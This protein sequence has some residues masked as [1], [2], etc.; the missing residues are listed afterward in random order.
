M[1]TAVLDAGLIFHA[2]RIHRSLRVAFQLNRLMEISSER[3]RSLAEL[4]ADVLDHILGFPC[5]SFMVIRLW[6]CCNRLL[7]KK[8]ASVITFLELRH[9]SV[10]LLPLRG[11]PRMLSELRGLRHLSIKAKE[12]KPEHVSSW[13]TMLRSLPKTLTTLKFLV[14]EWWSVFLISDVHGAS[15]D[16]SCAKP[17]QYKRGESSMMDLGKHFPHLQA[18]E[19][20]HDSARMLLNLI[21]ALPDTL[22]HLAISPHNTIGHRAF[23]RLPLSLT[24]L[25]AEVLGGV[26]DEDEDWFASPSP[27]LVCIRSIGLLYS[28]TQ[29]HALWMPRSLVKAGMVIG[30]QRTI[31]IC[32]MRTLP[33]LLDSLVIKKPHQCSPTC[34]L[35]WSELPSHLTS[36]KINFIV[37]VT[38]AMIF[39]LPRTI[40]LL[41]FAA[42]LK[43]DADDL[44]LAKDDNGVPKEPSFW[45]PLLVD[46]H[47][48]L[49]LDSACDSRIELLPRTLTA[50]KI[51][52]V[53]FRRGLSFNILGPL[54]PHLTTL[55]ATA[56]LSGGDELIYTCD[57]LPSTLI[58]VRFSTGFNLKCL[59][60]LPPSVSKLELCLGSEHI[61]TGDWLFPNAL[62]HLIIDVYRQEYF[63]YIPRTVKKLKFRY[64]KI[65]TAPAEGKDIF[66]SLPSGLTSLA[67][68]SPF[69]N[70][71][72]QLVSSSSFSSLPH[73]TKLEVLG[74]VS[75]SS[76][77][78]RGLPRSMKKLEIHLTSLEEKDLPFIP[79]SLQRLNFGPC[80][81][82]HQPLQTHC[83]IK[84]ALLQKTVHHSMDLANRIS[85]LYH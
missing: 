38:R 8:L 79:P 59:N 31:C 24:S 47:L 33:P 32:H 84:A 40:T 10:F 64:L 36:L 34:V 45:P 55:T 27:P 28:S 63:P 74:F 30:A 70:S 58:F 4:P 65:P 60:L 22:T 2:N 50:L 44:R 21:T 39:I 26:D 62:Q 41:E 68:T 29:R 19:L 81:T 17:V 20:E 7:T 12:L 56:L 13:R 1:H 80:V 66:Q 69:N 52:Y 42:P 46:L 35:V 72:P 9:S 15:F 85:S 57:D 54:P 76:D 73:L 6:K 82:W 53:A 25:D 67:V 43:F 48:T 18:L 3:A 71:E 14:P 5:S 23:F 51:H 75:S 61:Q 37:S 49:S 78:L 16:A 77:I 83:P 11:V